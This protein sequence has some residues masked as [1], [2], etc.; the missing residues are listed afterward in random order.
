MSDK[1]AKVRT[2]RHNI[3]ASEM[4]DQDEKILKI[5]DFSIFLYFWGAAE[6][7]PDTIYMY[8]TAMER[9]RNINTF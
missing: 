4:I 5:I 1:D 3:T 2:C 7:P 9:W 6:K 8:V